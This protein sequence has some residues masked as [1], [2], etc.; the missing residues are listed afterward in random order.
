MIVSSALQNR[1]RSWFFY[2]F[3][4]IQF[5]LFSGCNVF[6]PLD[7][8]S[9]DEDLLSAARACLDQG[10]YECARRYYEQLSADSNDSM[11]SELAF[12][13]LD[14]NAIGLSGILSALGGGNISGGKLFTLLANHI[15]TTASTEKRSALYGAFKRTQYINGS[16]MRGLVRFITSITLL[17]HLLAEVRGNGGL[18]TFDKGDIVSNEESC[19]NSALANCSTNCSALLPA[20]T[21]ISNAF[22]TSNFTGSVNLSMISALVSQISTALNSELLASGKFSSGSLSFASQLSNPLYAPSTSPACFSYL[23]ITNGL[24]DQ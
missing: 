14:E 18:A 15:G 21:V 3:F 16:Q 1:S 17:S 7:N 24:G 23:L 6:D 11:H 12:T 20:G 8:P 2:I 22:E 9:G 10:D 4:L 5:I 19:K 13:T